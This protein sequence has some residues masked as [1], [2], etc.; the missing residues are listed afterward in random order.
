MGRIINEENSEIEGVGVGEVDGCSVGEDET[1]KVGLTDG[2]DE[3]DVSGVLVGVGVFD[4]EGEVV[5]GKVD[6]S[7]DLGDD[8]FRSAEFVSSEAQG[9]GNTGTL[10]ETLGK[11]NSG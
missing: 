6:W 11:A 9:S 8:E 10:S 7:G 2:F 5:V 1:D 4:C 3:S